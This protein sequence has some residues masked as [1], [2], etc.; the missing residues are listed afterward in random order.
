M[1]KEITAYNPSNEKNSAIRLLVIEFIVLILIGAVLIFV[2]NYF[3]I[4]SF[5]KFNGLFRTLPS[6]RE[7][8][9]IVNE[10]LLNVGIEMP[11]AL[12][13]A[14][15]PFESIDLCIKGKVIDKGENFYGIGYSEVASGTKVL[16]VMQGETNLDIKDGRSVVTI[17]DGLGGQKVILDFIGEATMPTRNGSVEVGQAIGSIGVDNTGENVLIVSFQSAVNSE[18]LRPKISDDGSYV[19]SRLY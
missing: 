15:C 19:H 14:P 9:E 3:G 11:D 7:N 8:D 17:D 16:A 10:E 6:Q 13:F 12:P 2:L 1:K 5:K 4:I 18:F